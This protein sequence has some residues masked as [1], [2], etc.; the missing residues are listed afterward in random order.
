[1]K[2][3]D[4]IKKNMAVF[5]YYKNGILYYNVIDHKTGFKICA[6]PIDTTDTTDIGQATYPAECKAIYITR[7]INKAIKDDSLAYFKGCDKVF[8]EFKE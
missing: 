1:M 7:Y 8:E 6:V 2:V 5:D 4:I 3:I